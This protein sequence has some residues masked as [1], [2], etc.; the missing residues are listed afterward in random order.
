MWRGCQHSSLRGKIRSGESTSMSKRIEYID[1]ARGIGILL[2]VMGHNDFAVISPFAY[3][4]IYS[5]HMPLF[6]FLSGYFLNTAVGL[7]NFFK[8]R[9]HSLLKPYFFTIFLI[10][11]VSISFG[12][13]GFQTAIARIIK[14]LY[15][16]GHYLDWVQ[17]WFLPHLF[18]VSLFAYFFV[19]VI[20][21]TRLS[22]L[23]WVI[24][25]VFYVVGVFSINLFSPF[26]FNFFGKGF[27]VYGLPFSL[28][29][30]LVSG[31]FFMLAYELNQKRYTSLLESPL[32]LFISGLTLIFLVCYF[33][34]KIDFNIRRFDSL[35]INTI[36]ALLGILFI[37]TI[38]KQLER[39][40]G[41][42]AIFSYIGQASLII[43]IF[44]VPIQDYWGQKLLAL[45]NNLPLSYWISLDR[46][47]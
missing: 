19:H 17:L 21:Q 6:F 24:L 30:V 29:I 18:V 35:P 41:L 32:T 43:L 25:T 5:F 12:K 34:S 13:M 16:A 39:I 20:R 38:S 31:F 47:S 11:F 26:E 15:G 46:K 3:K 14:S 36:E 7:W 27:T 33:P 9:F 45:T 42:S 10:Y 28:D 40:G 23:R 2:V 37:L 8:K 44:Q 1:N 4:V 22:Q